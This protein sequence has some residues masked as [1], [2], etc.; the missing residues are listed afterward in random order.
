MIVNLIYERLRTSILDLENAGRISAVERRALME[1]S[2]DLLKDLAKVKD[3]R[4]GQ[5]L[6]DIITRASELTSVSSPVVT[7]AEAL[8]LAAEGLGY[9]VPKFTLSKPQAPLLSMA[10]ME[11]ILRSRELFQRKGITWV[12][13]VVQAAMG[14]AKT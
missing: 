4:L 1:L 13:A 3:E 12:E 7:W 9:K 2:Y 6:A 5:A 10:E 14:E 8:V 11:L